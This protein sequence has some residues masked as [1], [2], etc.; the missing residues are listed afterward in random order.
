[1]FISDF[2]VAI[3]GVAAVTSLFAGIAA[4]SKRTE[5]ASAS[6]PKYDVLISMV[7]KVSGQRTSVTL[8]DVAIE[9]QGKLEP[10]SV[11]REVVRPLY[12]A[13]QDKNH[14]PVISQ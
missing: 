6:K 2:L 11:A 13:S 10:K 4:A 14:A 8:E 7:N 5:E 3:S 1:M 9:I 12:K